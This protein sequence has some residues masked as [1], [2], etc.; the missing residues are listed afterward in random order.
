VANNLT[1]LRTLLLKL[2]DDSGGTLW[3][4]DQLN[5]G[6]WEGVAQHSY[7]FPA[8]NRVKYT[9]VAGMTEQLV[10][11]TAGTRFL[12]V[13][14]V[15]LPAGTPIPEDPRQSSDPAGSSSARYR[16]AW[17]WRN[18]TV[19]FRNALVGAEVGA[20]L[21]I[22]EHLETYV[23]PDAADV[24]AWSGSEWDLSLLMLLA[25]RSLWQELA[26]RQAGG[27]G[28]T[29]PTIAGTSTNV[30]IDIPPI[31]AALEVEI[32]RA[33]MARRRRAV[34]SRPLDI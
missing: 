16:Q 29:T 24:R 5:Q 13:G 31:L 20:N 12:G 2:I 34:R 21:L 8:P 15:E 1:T 4:N 33:L 10:T 30:H 6:L 7:L 27:Q 25:Q 14:R 18:G 9:T 32:A 22:I 26:G 17:W 28:L 3:N 11:N 23:F 19:Y